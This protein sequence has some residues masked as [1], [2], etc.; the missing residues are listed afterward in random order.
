MTIKL[1]M[2]WGCKNLFQYLA[3][4]S[5]TF[6]TIC[7]GMHY[8]WPSPS[9][10]KLEGWVD[11]EEGS[12]MA[13]MPLVG[14]VCGSLCGAYIVDIIGRKK[15]LLFAM[16]PFFTAWMLVAY[17][18]S[19]A[20]LMVARLL[21]GIADGLTFTA[22]P[23]YLGEIS[24]PKIRGL[25]GS[26][27]SVTWI[28]GIMLINA[29]GSYLEISLTALISSAFPA[30]C[31][32]TFIWMPET[33]YF[34]L[35][36][37]QESE[38]RRSLRIFNGKQEVERE[39]E[40][41]A[42][43]V[44]EHNASNGKW[45]NLFVVPS[46]RKALYVMMGTRGFQQL[47]GVSAITFYAYSIF[48]NVGDLVSPS[49]ASIIYFTIQVVVCTCCSVIVDRT[50]RRPLLIISITGSGIAL[51]VKAIYFL[52]KEE[53]E[54]DVDDYSVIPII[55]M[56]AF[57]LIFSIGMQSIPILLLGEIF[58]TDV[59]AFAV[60]FA[61]IYFSLVA[62]IVSKFFQITKDNYGLHVPFFAFSGFCF[63]GLLFMYHVVP[64]TNGKTLEEIQQCFRGKDSKETTEEYRKNP[65]I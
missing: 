28:F 30:L 18:K 3:M 26:S 12:W 34:L 44:K 61:D 62:T 29:I 21:A 17:G 41:M 8:G 1:E 36:K 47:A 37:G 11:N 9:L 53:T 55:A 40:V 31:F 60:C 25:L 65:E 52:I 10:P 23:I 6:S 32:V 20:V 42:E 7:S 22:L 14:A 46:N 58:P 38:A 43:E 33:P 5:G 51:L 64:E 59:K 16:F 63:L 24:D 54:I 56:I 45:L 19:F 35:M 48:D 4:V 15:T 50:G 49:V 13:V 27:V 57:V 2:M 39:L